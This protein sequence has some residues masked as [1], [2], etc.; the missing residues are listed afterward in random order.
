M[1][2]VGLT[3]PS[4]VEDPARVFAVAAAADASG[5]DAVFAYEHLFRVARDGGRRPAQDLWATMGALAVSTTHVRI[6]SL[7]ARA[8]LRPAAVM[9]HGFATLARIAPERVVAVLGAGDHESR[10]ENEE[11][12]LAFGTL[13]DRLAALD[14]AVSAVRGA[15]VET[16]IGGTHPRVLAAVAGA[17]GWNRWAGD[18]AQFAAERS[19]VVAARPGA[20]CTWG[21]LVVLADD[22]ATAAAKAA[23]LGAGAGTLIGAPDTVATALAPYVAAGAEWIVVAPVD[24]S[25]PENAARVAAVRAALT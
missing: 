23:R 19:T 11:F 24:S 3:L 16:W 22:D 7:V 20:V 21:G 9:A 1:V 5:L 12:G 17:D 25:D 2:A 10:A 6:G 15:G 8:T 18:P 4:F 13:D 14:D